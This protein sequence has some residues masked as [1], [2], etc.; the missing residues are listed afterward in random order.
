MKIYFALEVLTAFILLFLF[1]LYFLGTGI[2]ASLFIA[3]GGTIALSLVLYQKFF[4]KASLH[5][6]K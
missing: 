4:R 5:S 6:D 1:N 2:A 3:A